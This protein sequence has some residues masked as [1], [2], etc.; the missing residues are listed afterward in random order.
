VDQQRQLAGLFF[1]ALAS[2]WAAAFGRVGAFLAPLSISLQL[3]LFESDQTVFLLFTAV[4]GVDGIIVYLLRPGTKGRSRE[5]IAGGW[6]AR[7]HGR[8][9][10]LGPDAC[11]RVSSSGEE[12]W[13]AIGR[14]AAGDR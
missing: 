12:R 3:A 8:R 13:R 11:G 1:G 4:M 7:T 10:R 6:P 14:G 9:G 2:G 5:E